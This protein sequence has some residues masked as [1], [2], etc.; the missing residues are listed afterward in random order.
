M[1]FTQNSFFPSQP[2]DKNFIDSMVNNASVIGEGDVTIPVGYS[3]R[4]KPAPSNTVTTTLEYKNLIDN[5]L[6]ILVGVDQN[7]EKK[8]SQYFMQS[9][10]GVFGHINAAVGVNEV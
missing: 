3:Q 5:I 9:K 4:A 6:K 8:R 2:P 10:K 1:S 7:K